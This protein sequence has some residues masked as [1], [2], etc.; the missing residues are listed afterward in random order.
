MAEIVEVASLSI[1]VDKA[2][3]ESARLKGQIDSLKAAQKEL[4]TTTEAGRQ[5]FVKNAAEINNL[6]KAYRQSQQVVSVLN[7]KDKELKKTMSVENKSVQELTNSRAKLNVLSKNIRGNT[8]QEIAMRNKLNAAMNKQTE[9]IKGMTPAYVKQKNNI[10]NYQGAV[11]ALFPSLGSMITKIETIRTALLGKKAAMVE[12]TAVTE[13]NTTATEANTVGTEANAASQKAAATGTSLWTKALKFLKIA[14]AST[15][16]GALVVALGALITYLTTTQKGIDAVTKVLDPLKVMAQKMLGVLQQVGERVANIFKMKPADILKNIGNVIKSQIINR[17]TALGGIFKALGKII[18]SGFTK[19]YKELGNQTLQLTTGVTNLIDKTQAA[20]KK[21]AAFAK[22]ATAEGLKLRQINIDIENTEAQL[23]KDKAILTNEMKAQELIAKDTSKSNEERAAAVAK[24]S[25]L[26]KKLASEELGLQDLLIEKEKLK[27]S[28]N[29][30]G[31]KDAKKLNE[32]IAQRSE[33][34]TQQQKTALRF[35]GVSNSLKSEAAAA[36]AKANQEALDK[37]KA[38]A[39]KAAEEKVSIAQ[40]E[41]EQYVKD[42]QTKLDSNK[43][44]NEQSYQDE[45]NRLNSIAEKKKE[46]AAIAL[47]EGVSTQQEYNDAIAKIDDDNYAARQEVTNERKAAERDQEAV[48]LANKLAIIDEANNNEYDL[49]SQKLNRQREAEIRAAEKSGADVALINKKY[50]QRQQA[51]DEEVTKARL[52][53]YA[54]L[55]GNISELLGENTEA[56]KAAAIAQS[57]INTYQ[58]ITEVWKAPSVLPEPFNTASKIAASATTLASGLAAVKK[59]T[60]TSTKFSKGDILKGKSHARGG[61]PITINGQGGY[62]AEGGEAIINKK[63]TQLFKP[64][65]SSINVAG[66]GK[67]FAEG[68]ILGTA[69]ASTALIDYDLLATKIAVANANLPNPVVSVEEI[70]TVSNRVTAI[71]NIATL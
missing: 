23:A 66:G 2:V 47:E 33:I 55:F 12:D 69:T 71:E 18:S 65:L 29:D 15:G 49:Q 57:T 39:Q 36:E 37:E 48:D 63:S 27:Q 7:V 54:T 21:V 60:S 16:I 62:E 40:K 41:L 70:S 28:F 45:L 10:G 24:A 50:A 35:I 42:N 17:L 53:Q 19:G 59:I 68:G 56:G 8:E 30:S 20:G 25:S 61:I 43:F 38:A 1:N 4:D 14:I 22:E 5:Q 46:L 52:S 34:E 58:G 51:L 67:K 3:S 26:A 32:L 44:L 6:N 13:T 64:I 11:N 9:A 31:R